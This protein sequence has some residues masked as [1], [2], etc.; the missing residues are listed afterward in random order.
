MT[1]LKT[2]VVLNIVHTLTGIIFPIITF[3][4][5]ARI[6]LPEGIG[7]I[8]FLQSII[9]YIVLF[10]SLGIPLYAVR[11]VA[12]CKDDINQK[13]T[14]TFEILVLSLLLCALGYVAVFIIG[15]AVPQINSNLKTFYILSLT[16]LFS[17]LGVNWFY[18]AIEDF[19]FITI[20][21]VV[22]RIISAFSFICFCEG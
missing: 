11:E 14:T 16:I 22:F 20:R 10:T 17:S 13:N 12:R 7:T 4:Y 6:L 2:N 3:P 5:A 15:E 19:K 1:S 18:Q 21:S 8:G 9:S